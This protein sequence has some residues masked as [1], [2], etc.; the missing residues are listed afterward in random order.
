[1]MCAVIKTKKLIFATNNVAIIFVSTLLASCGSA[2]NNTPNESVDLSSAVDS[3]QGEITLHGE[4]EVRQLS[5]QGLDFH[6][7]FLSMNSP[8]PAQMLEHE[9]KEMSDNCNV[10]LGS[11]IYRENAFKLR[12]TFGPPESFGEYVTVSAGD[13]INFVKSDGNIFWSLF[14]FAD[15]DFARYSHDED[16]FDDQ[17][18]GG[19][20][21]IPDDLQIN[22]PGDVF[23]EFRSVSIPPI[24]QL[25]MS[26]PERDSSILPNTEF[27]WE[28]SGNPGGHIRI[29]VTDLEQ[30]IDCEVSDDGKFVFPETV[31]EQLGDDFIADDFLLART[32]LYLYQEISSSLLV[33][34][35]NNYIHSKG[36]FYY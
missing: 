27:I 33:K 7:V 4:I 2:Q 18:F 23:P 32:E 20:D 15:V 1:M 19:A 31:K 5:N 9:Y 14:K 11:P 24:R 8:F 34:R 30:T 36:K 25:A 26:M 3:V 13:T 29:L 6:A 21:V 12:S 22:I 28:A 17:Q 35:T 10:Y 16:P